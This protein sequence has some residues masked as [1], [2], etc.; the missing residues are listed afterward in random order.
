MI[1]GSE[2]EAKLLVRSDGST[3]GSLGSDELDREGR[4]SWR[5]CSGRAPGD[6]RVRRHAPVRGRGGARAAVVVLAPDYAAA[7]RCL[8]RARV[9]G[10]GSDPALVVRQSPERFPDA[11]EVVIGLAV[12]MPSVKIGAVS[13]ML[14]TSLFSR[15]IRS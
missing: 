2:L 11:E 13:I 14:P 5:S 6:A 9:G 4:S 1:S 8:K 10:R 7:F 3:D 12:G 15:T